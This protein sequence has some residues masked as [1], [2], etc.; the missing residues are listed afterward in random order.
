[1]AWPD[2]LHAS[3]SSGGAALKPESGL[4]ERVSKRDRANES[5]NRESHSE[6]QI[7]I[8][9]ERQRKRKRK[10]VRQTKRDTDRA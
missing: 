7:K 1:M 8:D 4:G 3:S 2:T 9:S 5:E 10:R 6:T